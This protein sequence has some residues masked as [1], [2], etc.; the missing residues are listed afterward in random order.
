MTVARPPTA[1]S[2]PRSLNVKLT[3]SP[4]LKLYSA[5]ANSNGALLPASL[6]SAVTA[7]AA[8][9]A[10]TAGAGAVAEAQPSSTVI[11]PTMARTS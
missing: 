8:A 5:G 1:T 10:A 3:V 11:V 2:M 7:V 6:R 9:G 4:T